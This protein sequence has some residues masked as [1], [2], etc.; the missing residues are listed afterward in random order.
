M[1]PHQRRAAQQS[2]SEN[3]STIIRRKGWAS[4][5]AQKEKD[6]EEEKARKAKAASITKKRARE[7]KAKVCYY[8]YTIIS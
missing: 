5:Q 4:E 2:Q 3:P 1:L 7:S 8:I 6:A